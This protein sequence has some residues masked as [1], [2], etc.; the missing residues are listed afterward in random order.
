MKVRKEL[1]SCRTS[2]KRHTAADVC[3]N[4][5][6]PTPG[7]RWGVLRS[8]ESLRSRRSSYRVSSRRP[9]V[10]RRTA[11]GPVAPHGFGTAVRR[12]LQS[13]SSSANSNG[14][15]T[16]R[17]SRPPSGL[18]THA[19]FP[20]TPF[21]TA[22]TRT[23]VYRIVRS[24]GLVTG[25]TDVIEQ[26]RSA[27][28]LNVTP[29]GAWNHIHQWFTVCDTRRLVDAVRSAVRVVNAQAVL[30]PV[31]LE[32]WVGGGVACRWCAVGESDASAS[33]VPSPCNSG[34]S[35][36]ELKGKNG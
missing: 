1:H 21:R 5:A 26:S 16:R 23:R 19:P 30:A 15:G 12:S 2:L 18:L 9:C 22:C 27:A 29:P 10:R 35:F 4:S 20:G 17:R 25:K 32:G 31:R 8:F 3:L 6:P 28:R 11:A 7:S 14:H 34:R 33:I 24:I 13:R 36:L